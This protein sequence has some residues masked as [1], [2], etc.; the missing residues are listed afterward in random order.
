MRAKTWMPLLIL[1]LILG[2][3]GAIVWSR[4]QLRIIN[5]PGDYAS[6]ESALASAP[7]GA[8]V[9]LAP[10]VYKGSLVIE[11]PLTIEGPPAGTA[12]IRGDPDKPAITVL[13]ARDVTIRRLTITEGKFGVLVRHSEGV[14]ITDN[15]I[16]RNRLRGVRVVYGTAHILNN[17]ISDTY[18]PYGKGI[19]IANSLS[20]PDS[21]VEGN[22]VEGNGSEGIITNLAQAIIKNNIVR[23]NNLRGIA[24]F[25][26]SVATV[27]DNVITGNADAGLQILDM[28]TAEVTGNDVTGTRL[29]PAGRADG[30]R[31]D[32]HSEA[33]LTGNKIAGNDGCGISA[34]NDSIVTGADNRLNDNFAQALCG[35]LPASLMS[36]TLP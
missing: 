10:G 34:I 1:P 36:L 18:S 31:L 35:D 27:R 25:E 14:L 33:T 3:F 23:N 8:I 17:T 11:R 22:I 12:T 32:Y 16:T 5:V 28:S 29:G 26:M 4:A 20:W 13:N 2:L 15:L 7:A 21:L 9:R 19:H 6:I 24:I 30:I